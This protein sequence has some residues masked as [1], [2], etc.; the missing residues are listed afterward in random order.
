MFPWD[1]SSDVDGFDDVKMMKICSRRHAC[2]DATSYAS[3]L[4]SPPPF[5]SP[6]SP[7]WFELGLGLPI[8]ICTVQY[9]DCPRA[10]LSLLILV[11]S[12]QRDFLR[13]T[14]C[15]LARPYVSHWIYDSCPSFAASCNPWITVLIGSR[16]QQ[17]Y[18]WS[19]NKGRPK[20]GGIWSQ[21]GLC[22]DRLFPS[23]VV[24]VIIWVS[25]I[26]RDRSLCCH[27]IFLP[28]IWDHRRLF[29]EQ[30]HYS[31]GCNVLS[32]IWIHRYASESWDG[33]GTGGWCREW[34]PH[35]WLSCLPLW[36]NIERSI[37][38]E[39]PGKADQID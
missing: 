18:L 10:R 32:S 24:F 29:P 9:H 22:T 35:A 14:D 13:A 16:F 38:G 36:C 28:H 4:S 31:I 15:Q 17:E 21:V 1:F 2:C 26:E 19:A 6:P 23:E 34:T 5:V 30:V 39:I 33:W 25:S 8:L 37:H 3:Y 7:L 11:M 12:V 27:H 20:L